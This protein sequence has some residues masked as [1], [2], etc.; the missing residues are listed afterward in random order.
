MNNSEGVQMQS[1]NQWIFNID[2]VL[3]LQKTLLHHFKDIY[4]SDFSGKTFK[5]KIKKN[6]DNNISIGFLYGLIEDQVYNY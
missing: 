1:L 2:N 5:L 6:I 3:L 4:I